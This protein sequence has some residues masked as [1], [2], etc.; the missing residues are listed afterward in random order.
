[1]QTWK[2][3]NG[4]TILINESSEEYAR[5]LGWVPVKENEKESV[6]DDTKAPD[7]PVKRK[8]RP[9]KQAD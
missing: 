1:M 6:L 7:A 8:G 5:E 9:K 2:K 3:P 4:T